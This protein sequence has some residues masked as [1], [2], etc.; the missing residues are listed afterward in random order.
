MIKLRKL[1][2]EGIL[3]GINASFIVDSGITESTVKHAKKSLTLP[4]YSV[5]GYKTEGNGKPK[6]MENGNDLSSLLEKHNIEECNVYPIENTMQETL[7]K[8]SENKIAPRIEKSN[9]EDK[10][11]SKNSIN[12]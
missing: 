7:K 2:K 4:R 8:I 1:L 3:D 11:L 12:G 9:K 10:K 5:W 6:L